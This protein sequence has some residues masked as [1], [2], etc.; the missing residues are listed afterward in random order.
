[1]NEIIY[2]ASPYSHTDPAVVQS[3][4]ETIEVL[5]TVR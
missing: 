4:F 3:N 5:C 2:I 1:M